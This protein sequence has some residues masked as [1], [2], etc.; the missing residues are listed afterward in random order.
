M[1]IKFEVP[2]YVEVEMDVDNKYLPLSDDDAW[3]AQLASKLYDEAESFLSKQESVVTKNGAKF[4]GFGD[5][6][7]IEDAEGNTLWED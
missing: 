1:K 4:T 2:A 7:Y 5:I 3:T 6:C